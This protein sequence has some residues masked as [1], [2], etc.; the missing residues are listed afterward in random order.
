[1]EEKNH[2]K[3][4]GLKE[5]N[6]VY[7]DGR[8]NIITAYEKDLIIITLSATNDSNQCDDLACHLS[9]ASRAGKSFCS[10]LL[11]TR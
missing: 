1:M 7:E 4:K 8:Q 3:K 6:A 5:S 9:V 2:S 11:F 10:S